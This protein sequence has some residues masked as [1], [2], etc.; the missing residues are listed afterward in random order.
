MAVFTLFKQPPR[1][2]YS[3]GTGY[4][5][6]GASLHRGQ[7]PYINITNKSMKVQILDHYL[8]FRVHET[9]LAQ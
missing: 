6:A 7:P 4:F 1:T 8:A 9:Y 2:P 5:N 3:N